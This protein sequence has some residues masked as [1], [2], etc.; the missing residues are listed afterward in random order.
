M[1]LLGTYWYVTGLVSAAPLAL[2]AWRRR[3]GNHFTHLPRTALYALVLPSAIS[4]LLGIATTDLDLRF[5]WVVP[6]SFWAFGVL[7]LL[8]VAAVATVTVRYPDQRSL[9]LA[10]APLQLWLTVCVNWASLIAVSGFGKH[11]R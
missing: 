2:L 5:D 8:G 10:I 7:L 1:E 6:A 3:R 4:L 9:L 11:W